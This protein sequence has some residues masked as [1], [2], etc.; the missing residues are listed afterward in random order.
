MKHEFNVEWISN[1]N[2]HAE[3]FLKKYHPSHSIPVPIEHIAEFKLGMDIIPVPGLKDVLGKEGFD[4]DGFISSDFSSISVDAYVYEKYETRYRFTLAHEISHKLLHINIYE[5]CEF[6]NVNEWISTVRAIPQ[7]TI[8][9]AEWQARELAGLILVPKAILADEFNREADAIFSV[10]SKDHPQIVQ[11]ADEINYL[12]F[13]MDVTI[14]SLA[15]K[16]IV[17][18]DTIRI[19]LERDGLIDRRR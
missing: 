4:I 12:G 9:R 11:Y 1:I 19:R 15:K 10:Y 8:D 5:Q 17:S 2:A 16:F 6:S 18:D 7:E 3:R 14:H 13:I